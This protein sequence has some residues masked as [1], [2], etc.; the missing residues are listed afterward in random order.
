MY[1]IY[2]DSVLVVPSASLMQF[3]NLLLILD[4]LTFCID[5]QKKID[6]C[7]HKIEVARSEVVPNDEI[8]RLQ[9]DLDEKLKEEQLLREELR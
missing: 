1:A 4:M 9:K 7:K 6:D 5:Y 3:K 8:D 2:S